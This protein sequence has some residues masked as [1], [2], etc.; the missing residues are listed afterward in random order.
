MDYILEYYSMGLFTD[1]D[2]VDFVSVGMITQKQYDSVK[3]V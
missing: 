3:T 2:M 1:S